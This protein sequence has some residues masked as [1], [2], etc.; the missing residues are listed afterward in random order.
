MV[1]GW[2]DDE[3]IGYAF[4]SPRPNSAATW[5]EVRAGL[6]D[7]QTPA[8]P[9]PIYIFREFAVHPDHQ[10]KGHG[11]TIHDELLGARPEPL[12]HLLVRVENDRARNAYISWGWRKIG[13]VRP[14]P[15]APV[16]E[17]M[18]V[19]LPLRGTG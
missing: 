7:M 13:T 11:R 15:E 4:G 18:V 19:E 16:M 8:E 10:G 1:S 5:A 14:F 2:L 6:P 12:A 3:L 17:A 9:E